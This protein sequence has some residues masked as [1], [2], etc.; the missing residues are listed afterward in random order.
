MRASQSDLELRRLLRDVA[1][2]AT[3]VIERLAAD[4]ELLTNILQVNATLVGQR[5]NEEMARLTEAGYDQNEQVKRMFPLIARSYALQFAQNELV[6]KT[7]RP[8][9]KGSIYKLLNNRTFV[10]QVVHKGNMYSGEHQAIVPQDLWDRAACV[11]VIPSLKKAAF[12]VGGEYWKGLMSCR[13]D[14]AWSAPVFMELEKGS[15]GFQ[16]GAESIDL[17]LLVLT[18]DNAP[19][20]SPWISRSRPAP[21]PNRRPSGWR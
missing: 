20:Q 11:I 12:I 16:I 17:V 2:H 21:S 7:G 13:R 6:A 4:R 18:K 15:W 1:Y 8:F 3:R 14:G 10:D 5:Q 19:P 9:D